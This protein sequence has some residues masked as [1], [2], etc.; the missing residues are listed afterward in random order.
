MSNDPGNEDNAGMWKSGPGSEGGLLPPDI[1]KLYESLI[2]DENDLNGKKTPSELDSYIER[3]EKLKEEAD[4]LFFH[5]DSL[6][7]YRL[8]WAYRAAGTILVLVARNTEDST[9]AIQ[10]M[11]KAG[12][13]LHFAGHTFRKEEE[14]RWSG[15]SYQSSGRAFEDCARIQARSGVDRRRIVESYDN[16]IRSFGRAKGVFGEVG[17]YDLSGAAYYEEQKAITGKLY[18]K[19][20]PLYILRMLWAYLTGYGEKMGRWFVSYA[21]GVFA[22]TLVNIL[23]GLSLISSLRTAFARSLLIPVFLGSTWVL[24]AQYIY[25]YFVL[26]F[27]LTILGRKM[28]SR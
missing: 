2:P 4:I 22:F 15:E 24:I 6:S 19:R 8:A 1:R 10:L 3:A 14:Y 28:Q 12:Q 16:V 20:S 27:A 7:K 11:E 5:D 17:D 26:S 18:Y 9:K 13:I 23:Q 25:S 21:I